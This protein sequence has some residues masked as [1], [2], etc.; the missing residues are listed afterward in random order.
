[1]IGETE[2]GR[3]RQD[4]LTPSRRSAGRGGWRCKRCQTNQERQNIANPTPLKSSSLMWRVVVSFCAVR[5]F[6]AFF[7]VNL[8][9]KYKFPHLLVDF[10][11][12]QA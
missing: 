12:S 6:S 9:Q 11:R 8:L 4:K 1:M 3:C 2:R 7:L 10:L 5:G